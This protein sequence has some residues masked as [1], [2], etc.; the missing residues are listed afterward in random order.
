MTKV[1]H[2]LTFLLL[3]VSQAWIP[4]R[5]FCLHLHVGVSYLGDVR[6]SAVS[7]G[8][9]DSI[10]T[11]S[12]LK[13]H[14][15]ELQQKLL[16]DE[17]FSPPHIDMSRKEYSRQS[18]LKRRIPNLDI[19]NKIQIGASTIPSGGRGLF[20]TR[21]IQAGE[22]I[23]CYPGDALVVTMSENDDED[24]NL[25]AYSLV[26]GSHVPPKFQFADAFELWTTST[27]QD[28]SASSDDDYYSPWTGYVVQVC[29]TYSVLGLPHLDTDVTYAGHFANDSC[30]ALS[31]KDL[32]RYVLKSQERANAQHQQV[33]GLHVATVA[34]R[35]MEPGEE[36][37]VTYGPDYWRDQWTSS[38]G[39]V[40][41]EESAY[42]YTLD[43]DELLGYYD[44][45]D[46]ESS[47]NQ[48]KGFGSSSS[49]S[50]GRGFG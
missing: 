24:N 26:W 39:E 16:Q 32:S 4:T 47:S 6:L 19:G 46:D 42:S 11:V 50:G 3:V 10:M 31:P 14:L 28:T 22:V 18:M 2:R 30:L 5:S 34:T 48:G 36:I 40:L 45:D 27:S 1:A 20:S 21:P 37:F 17:T 13:T 35:A 12:S 49:S 9:D 43:D 44:D 8:N 41:E 25:A 7:P 33:M 23:T 38:N 15:L 29:D